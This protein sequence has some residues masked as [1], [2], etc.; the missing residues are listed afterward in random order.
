MKTVRNLHVKKTISALGKLGQEL[1]NTANDK[2]LDGINQAY[3]EV[4]A[5][6]TAE[7]AWFTPSFI[8][9]AMNNI[10]EA[11]KE[12]LLEAWVSPYSS[13]TESTRPAYAIGV[14]LAGNVPLVGFHDFISVLASGNR[15]L[16]KL[17]ADD[18]QLLP[19]LAARLRSFYPELNDYIAFTEHKLEN[20]DAVIATGSNNTA[21]YF[22]YYFGKYPNI[23][24]KNRNGVAVLTGSESNE[25]LAQLAD[26]VF[27]YFGLGCRNV[28][29]L[30]VPQGYEFDQLLKAFDAY[31]QVLDI[32][33]YKNNYDYYKSIYLINSVPHLDNGSVLL[34][35]SDA[36][37]SPPSVMY[38]EPYDNLQALNDRLHAL[39]EQVQCVV[40]R[41]GEITGAIPFGQAQKP[42]LTDYA[43]GIDTMEFLLSIKP[44]A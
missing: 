42:G 29:K 8:R 39:V 4:I 35:G 41:P 14:V 28:S 36:L 22:E 17:S 2:T 10:G 31:A 32:S 30:F 11:L 33:K 13:R 21:R 26:D 3:E 25:E 19:F 38:Y 44:D 12:D 27:L 37:S 43:D 16:G 15:F 6:A 23:I 5:R 9:I 1:R 20:F 18:K 40:G 7:N 34:T 24:R